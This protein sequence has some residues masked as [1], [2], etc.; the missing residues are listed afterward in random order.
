MLVLL[1]VCSYARKSVEKKKN[2]EEL[3]KGSIF[4]IKYDT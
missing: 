1:I 2:S 4:F 3:S